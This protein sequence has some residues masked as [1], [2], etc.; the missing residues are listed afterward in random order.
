LLRPRLPPCF[1]PLASFS[2]LPCPPLIAFSSATPPNPILPTTLQEREKLAKEHFALLQKQ[3]RLLEAQ[4]A[5][6]APPPSLPEAAPPL[7]LPLGPAAGGP[8]LFALPP[9]SGAQAAAGAGLPS[10]ATALE[11]WAA[12]RGGGAA[13]SSFAGLSGLLPPAHDRSDSLELLSEQQG[14]LDLLND[15]PAEFVGG[16][17]APP[18]PFDAADSSAAAGDGPRSPCGTAASGEWEPAGSG[19]LASA[20]AAAHAA[21]LA[22]PGFG[23]GRWSSVEGS[24]EGLGGGGGGG[25]GGAGGRAESLA[26]SAARTP[27]ASPIKQPAGLAA[28]A[29]GSAGTAAAAPF[30]D[31][32]GGG[33]LWA[34]HA[35]SSS[36]GGTRSSWPSDLPAMQPALGGGGGS[37][38]A[39]V[40]SGGVGS[41]SAAGLLWGSSG[42]LAAAAGAAASPARPTAQDDLALVGLGSRLWQ[43]AAAAPHSASSDGWAEAL[44]GAPAGRLLASPQRPPAGAQPG[45]AAALAL[46]QARR[47]QQLLAALDA[48]KAQLAQQAQQA[49]QR[50]ICKYFLHGFCREVKLHRLYCPA[51][52]QPPPQPA[53]RCPCCFRVARSM[54][55]QR[56]G[57]G[58]CTRRGEAGGGFTF[59]C[60]SAVQAAQLRLHPWT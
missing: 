48:A 57:V 30:L 54:G 26:A 19:S 5:A 43:P 59:S 12:A 35:G 40:S 51:R 24:V 39:G 32:G 25:G 3:R 60:C 29:G 42:N 4:A 18:T 10:A 46:L 27:E 53:C 41:S 33:S 45:G 38:H 34:A 36:G 8:G 22:A 6:A 56:V 7:P 58:T 44:G 17:A 28:A 31:F 14:L 47:Q 21:A 23:S 20:A 50:P 2:A 9:A 37:M 52:S 49:Q 15:Q 13:G 11:L 1:L 16:A 55:G